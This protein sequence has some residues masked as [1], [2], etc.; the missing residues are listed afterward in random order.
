[1]HIARQST[2]VARQEWRGARVSCQALPVIAAAADVT[3]LMSASVAGQIC[4]QYYVA[5]ALAPLD[6]AVGI[7]L[8]SS[9]LFVLLAR[10]QGLYRLPAVLGPLPYLARVVVTFAVSQL[11]VIC[12]LFLLKVGAEYSRGAMIVFAAFAVGLA[13]TGRLI[14]GAASR[15]GVRR[16]AVTGRRV[17]TI[18]DPVELERLSASDFLQ[19]GIE[20]IARIGVVGASNIGGL[21]DVDFR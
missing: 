20:D 11:A 19:Y 12:I 13:P 10:L 7:G 3:L 4:Y 16:G 15:Y 5:N 9:I 17:V 14:L 18:G 6:G 21:G 1:M 8:M 2:Y